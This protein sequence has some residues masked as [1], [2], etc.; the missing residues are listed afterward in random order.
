MTRPNPA[1]LDVVQLEKPTH[2]D[3]MIAGLERLIARLRKGEFETVVVLGFTPGGQWISKELGR[4]HSRLEM[5]GILEI[6]KSD[7]IEATST[8][9]RAGI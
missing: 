9:E 7:I 2:I 3:E 8:G 5:V 1:S 6:L 4:S